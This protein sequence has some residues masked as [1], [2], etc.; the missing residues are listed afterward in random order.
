MSISPA[1]IASRTIGVPP[2]WMR[3][4][5]GMSLASSTCKM[6]LPSTPPSVS[7]LEETTTCALAAVAVIASAAALRR[8]LVKRMIVSLL[9]RTRGRSGFPLLT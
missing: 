9:G 8:I 3:S 4:S 1:M 5:T 2:N 6:I 7:I